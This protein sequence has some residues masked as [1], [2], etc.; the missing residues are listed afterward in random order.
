MHS[1]VL[2]RL[3][4]A[5]LLPPRSRSSGLSPTPAEPALPPHP[6]GHCPLSSQPP[7]EP[8]PWHVMDGHTQ[9]CSHTPGYSG[10]GAPS[11]AWQGGGRCWVPPSWHRVGE[12]RQCT[13]RAPNPHPFPSPGQW[14]GKED[15][16]LLLLLSS[17]AGGG[18]CVCATGGGPLKAGWQASHPVSQSRLPGTMTRSGPAVASLEPGELQDTWVPPH[19]L[20]SP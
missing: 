1:D 6:A 20:S 8:D 13:F 17:S 7:K 15:F 19:L 16:L 2:T 12:L 9:A 14:V 4:N 18:V 11:Y 10:V 5:R 3:C